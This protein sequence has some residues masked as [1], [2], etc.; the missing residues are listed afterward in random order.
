ML[1]IVAYDINTSDEDGK[2]RLNK[3]S[4]ICKKYGQRVQDSLFE[5]YIDYSKC[6]ELKLKLEKEID[7]EKD[8]VRLYMIGNN[9]KNKVFY[10]GK[11]N[12][13]NLENSLIF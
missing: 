13:I 6:I 3:I 2:K 10:L 9:Y 12:L 1:L 4:K 8:T 7:K 5:C 11:D